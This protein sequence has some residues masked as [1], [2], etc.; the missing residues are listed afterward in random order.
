MFKGLSLPI[1]LA[2]PGTEVLPTLIYDLYEGGHYTR[3]NAL[4]ILMFVFLLAM[5]L[6][7]HRMSRQVGQLEVQ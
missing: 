4:G 2:G 6:I 7:A 1:L 3:L 5:S